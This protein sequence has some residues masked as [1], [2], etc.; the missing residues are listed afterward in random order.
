MDKFTK[1]LTVNHVNSNGKIYPQHI[2]NKYIKEYV[3]EQKKRDDMA[4]GKLTRHVLF[5]KTK[6]I[7]LK[8]VVSQFVN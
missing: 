5:E 4:R 8:G 6:K 1:I 7:V 2:F 3:E